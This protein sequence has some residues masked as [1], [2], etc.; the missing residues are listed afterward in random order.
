MSTIKTIKTFPGANLSALIDIASQN[1]AMQGFD[2][3]SQVMG[4]A[5]A[6]IIVTKDRDGLK[7]F[8]GLGLECR[9]AITATQDVLTLT[10]NSEWTNK[11][12]ALAIGWI[13]CWV[14]FITGVVGTINQLTL[15]EKIGT[16]FALA[17]NSNF[18]GS[19]ADTATPV[20]FTPVD[21]QE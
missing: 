11:I 19:D 8:L 14:P 20:D 1:L 12:I 13:L 2:V 7:N 10:I 6:E 21:P 4:P 17:C 18:T 15:P 9:V 3:K 16:A 5:A